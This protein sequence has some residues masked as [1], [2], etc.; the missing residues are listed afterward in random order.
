MKSRSVWMMV[1]AALAVVAGVYFIV[2]NEKKEDSLA[3]VPPMVSPSL[4]ELPNLSV[5][6]GDQSSV[7]LRELTG[8]VMLVFFNP[9][10]DH[11]HEEAQQMAA[12]KDAF[13]DWQVYFI[14][15]T[16]AKSAEEFG[17]KFRLTSPNFHFGSA[18]VSDVYNSVGALNQVPT[19]MMFKNRMFLEKY[20]GITPV[21]DLKR[22]L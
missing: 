3:L 13:D 20:E 19:I 22:N 21:A 16:D 18:S 7:L 5:T 8:N 15:S 4:N 14:A 11:C 17:V 1:I 6:L 9:D 12:E 10:C 2:S